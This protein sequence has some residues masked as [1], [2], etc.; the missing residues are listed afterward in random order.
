MNIVYAVLVL[1]IMGAIFGLVLAIASKVFAVEVDPRQDEILAVLPG[2]N[3]GGCGF[4]GCSGYAAAIVAGTAP[5]NACAAGGANVAAKIAEIMGVEAGEVERTVAFVRCSGGPNASKK[6]EYI[7]IND[8]LS[9]SRLQGGG[10]LDCQYGCLGLGT[11]TTACKFGAISVVDGLA[12]VD[13]EKCVGCMACAAVCP[14]KVI[15][16]VPYDA[17]VRVPCSSKDK[18]AAVRKYCTIG[19]IGCKVCEKACPHDAIHVVDNVASIDYSKCVGCGACV[20][21]C[22]RK[23]IKDIRQPKEQSVEVPA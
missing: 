5:M 4:P 6:Y 2:A 8:C 22:P 23:L 16:K 3:C 11:C 10:A 9:A 21:K 20:Q 19:C 17:N 18:G 13:H 15:V 1:G 7:G 14:R 12:R